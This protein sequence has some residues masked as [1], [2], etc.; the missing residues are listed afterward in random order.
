M[1][2]YKS[3]QKITFA[4]LKLSK[5]ALVWWKAFRRQKRHRGALSWKE[6]KA[7]IRKK[8]YPVGYL[9]ERWFKWYSLKQVYNQSM[10]EY[11]SEF[12]N[13]GMALDVDLDDYTIY[14]KYIAGLHEYIR[15]ELKMFSVKSITEASIKAAAIEGRLKRHETKGSKGKVGTTSVADESKEVG[16]S[17]GKEGLN[18]THC[19][20]TGHLVDKC[21][22]KFPQLKP[23]KLQQKDAKKALVAQ[24]STEVQELTESSKKIA[25]MSRDGEVPDQDDPRERLF[26]VKMQ[27]K[28][29]L[30]DAVI[31]SGSQKNLISQSLVKSLGLTTS[32]HSCPYPL[33]WIQKEGGLDIVQQCKFK[34]ALDEL[35]I[36]EVTCDVVS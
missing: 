27:I 18:C 9:E 23:K 3:S 35:Y 8:F 25:L 24:K 5:H 6:F 16:Q 29:T 36:D 19:N 15:K 21:W 17:K 1:Y 28:T 10:Q 33:G 32:K 22:D 11:T 26:Q 13:Q 31:D 12:S 30:V 34:F 2:D 14:M 20:Q 7:A 4:V